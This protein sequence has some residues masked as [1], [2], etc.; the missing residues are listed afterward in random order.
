M[1]RVMGLDHDL[2]VGY[3]AGGASMAVALLMTHFFV[4]NPGAVFVAV[5]AWVTLTPV[6]ILIARRK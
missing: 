1:R 5:L 2:W 6:G 3:W 4:D